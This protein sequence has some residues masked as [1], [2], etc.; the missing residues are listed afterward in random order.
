[1][2]QTGKVIPDPQEG[3]LPV[4]G[5]HHRHDSQEENKTD[6]AAGEAAQNEVATEE[7]EEDEEKLC[8]ECEEE[9]ARR[10]CDQCEDYFCGDCYDKLHHSAKR[11]KHTWKA[12]GP[13][14][15]IECDKMKATRWCY[16]CQ[17]PYCLGCF[18]I[19]HAKGNKATHDWTDMA[20]FRKAKKQQQAEEENAQTYDEFMQSNEYQYVNE[21]TADESV[22]S[23]SGQEGEWATMY[24]EASGQYYYYNSYTGE[25]RWA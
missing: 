5:G 15:C 8:V 19:I 10:K 25:S 21:L 16:V 20:A 12:V 24:D 22:A 3:D 2:L 14:R 1:M 18:T 17:D 7:D 23:S 9:D 4:I 11:G 13:I 6:G